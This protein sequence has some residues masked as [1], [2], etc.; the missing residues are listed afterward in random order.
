MDITQ[1]VATSREALLIGD[2]NSYRASLS[3]RLLAT[4]K[5]LGRATH[6]KEKFA[7]KPV[8]AEDVASNH[9][10]VHLLLLTS[11]RAWAHAMHVKT[12]HTDDNAGKGITGSTRNYI[13]SRLNKA[14]K[15][16]GE[17]LQILKDTSTSK[18]NEQDLLE[19]RA[20]QTAL[21]GAEEF[22]K[23]SEGQ[24]QADA[25]ASEKR[26]QK[27]LQRYSEARVI[28]AALLEKE[29]KEIYRD[30]LANTVDPTIRY[31]AY[32]AHLSRTIPIPTVAKRFF[33]RE[34]AELVKA[35]QAIDASALEDK[36]APKAG[37]DAPAESM[38]IPNSVTWRGRKA[39]IVDASI[40][41]ALANVSSA[42]AKLRAYLSS[43]STSSPREKAAAYD[44]VLIAS[45]DAADAAKS[46]T[47]ELEKER[48]DE[49][50]A[51]MQD[52][53]VTS[54]SVNYDLVSWRVGRNRVLIGEDDGLTFGAQQQKKSKKLRKDG[55]P[56]PEQ[57]E[58]RG[59]RLARLR[60]R[61]VLYD[62]TIQSVNSVKDLRGAMRDP[63]FVEE[64]D[65]KVDYFRALKCLNISYS[66]SLIGNHLNALALLKRAQQL[67]SRPAPAST[68]A[69][70]GPPT[71]DLQPAAFDKLKAHVDSLTS[72]LHAIVEMQSL[73]ANSA[74]AAQKHMSSA[75]PIV[76]RLND[77][78]TPGTMVDLTNL[79][80]YP[81]KIEAVPVKPLFLDVA[82]NYIDYPGRVADNE[83][84]SQA[85][86]PQQ[87]QQKQVNGTPQE[88]AA[89]PAPR[90][91]WFGFGR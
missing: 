18:A 61:N 91:G 63:A 86:V 72:R 20:Y 15:V 34:D 44:D 57:E 6:K 4:R 84:E 10:F 17:L 81:P 74:K 82:F 43:N 71:L 62:A 1:F 59:R 88:T 69:N 11:E 22:E 73:E 78:P 32:Q 83:E 16:A 29:K 85:A 55:T 25:Q 56:Y 40:G 75:A 23:Q 41:Q 12:T 60:E 2:Y 87:Q 90:K 42:E 49:G 50:D 31:A 38:D 46:A 14:A 52:L 8:T 47:D 7:V 80:T 19:T 89:Q 35:V 65:G 54:L 3:R 70:D 9:E 76:Q 77:Y 64:L 37:D 66:H 33:P 48:V 26:W 51:R 24:R 79:V 13:I 45:Q 67:V 21:S 27:C 28:Y 30:V 36:P 68:T 39:N 5:R 53:R 58:P